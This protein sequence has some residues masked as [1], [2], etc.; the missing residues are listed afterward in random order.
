MT[1][2]RA[3]KVTANDTHLEVLKFLVNE[4]D[5]VTVGQQLLE[6]GTSKA[7]FALE[8]PADGFVQFFFAKGDFCP[9][10]EILGRLHEK[11]I[12]ESMNRRKEA[13]VRALGGV[14]QQALPASLTVQLLIGSRMEKI[15]REGKDQLYL[16]ATII[17]S[18]VQAIA[19][20]PRFNSFIKEGRT[21]TR[22]RLNLGFALNLTDQLNVVV[23]RDVD[24]MS[25]EYIV[26]EILRKML[27][28]QQGKLTPEDVSDASFTVTSLLAEN[29]FSFPPLLSD[30]QSFAL[31]IGGDADLPGFPLTLTI[32]YDHRIFEGREVAAVLNQTKTDWL[33]DSRE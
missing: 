16:L 5:R 6:L 27:K 18:L 4:G 29:I 2:I 15:R 24:K 10:G 26:S 8:S 30:G 32:T 13:Q 14:F 9:V 19:P 20:K 28:S 1:E 21:V 11:P 25:T 33:R 7:S 17:H 23:I 22:D 12:G 3:P 31:G